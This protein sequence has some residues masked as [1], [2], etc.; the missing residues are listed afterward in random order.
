MRERLD[1]GILHTIKLILT[2]DAKEVKKKHVKENY[3]FFLDVMKRSFDEQD[4]QTAGMLAIALSDPAITSIKF[5]KPKKAGKW[6][7][8]VLEAH[9]WANA[10]KHVEF[11]LE[12]D[13]YE[14]LPSILTLTIFASR[15]KLIGRKNDVNKAELILQRYQDLEIECEQVLPIYKQRRFSRDELNKLSKELKSAV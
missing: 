12:T 11:L 8:S 10:A 3:R 14:I 1:A 2:Q 7:Q 13:S 6:V 4:H 5:K 15:Q 9:G